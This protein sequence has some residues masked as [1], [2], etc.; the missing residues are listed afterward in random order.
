[1]KPRTPNPNY[2][3][4]PLK[5]LAAL[6]AKDYQPSLKESM[7]T[8]LVQL[9]AAHSIEPGKKEI[10][11]A[12]A[13]VSRVSE[14]FFQHAGKEERLLF[15]LCSTA[16]EK[17]A[18]GRDIKELVQ[19]IAELKSEHKQITEEIDNIR[20]LTN[21]YNYEPLAS[22]SQ[23]L[24]YAQL[25]EFEQDVNRLIY[26]EEEFLFPRLLSVYQKNKPNT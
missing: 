20:A 8:I 14:I 21:T 23:K 9:D 12:R 26:I 19:F 25:N 11:T 2:A 16:T 10:T 13:F 15:P 22:P 3:Q 6:I 4:L 24:A 7:N 18:S 5:E 17:R 1:M